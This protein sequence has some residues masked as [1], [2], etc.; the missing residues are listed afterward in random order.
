MDVCVVLAFLDGISALC[1]RADQLAIHTGSRLACARRAVTELAFRAFLEQHPLRVLADLELIVAALEVAVVAYRRFFAF[2]RRAVACKAVRACLMRYPV[3]IAA[4]IDIAVLAFLR[5]A[6]AFR[7]YL[8]FARHFGAYL[9]GR[10]DRIIRKAV[11]SAKLH[12]VVKASE[13]TVFARF[14]D[15]GAVFARLFVGACLFNLIERAATANH[16]RI[17]IGA[18]FARVRRAYRVAVDAEIVLARLRELWAGLVQRASVITAFAQAY[19]RFVALHG[20]LVGCR[21]QDALG[22]SRD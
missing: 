19:L 3:R 15:A 8:A 14:V 20:A 21:N 6:F 10:A 17:R 12:V 5:V 2:K 9:R 4:D 11:V 1:F 18:A 7:R 13:R 22:T 16:H